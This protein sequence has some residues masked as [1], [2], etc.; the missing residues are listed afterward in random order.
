MGGQTGKKDLFNK[1]KGLILLCQAF[2]VPQPS[3]VECSHFR[4]R[5]KMIYTLH[6]QQYYKLL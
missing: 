2:Q 5:S 3:P 1:G 6:S 4:P